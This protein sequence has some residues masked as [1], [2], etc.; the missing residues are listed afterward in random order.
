MV[1]LFGHAADGYLRLC[2]DLLYR[3]V[4]DDDVRVYFRASADG[5]DELLQQWLGGR[6]VNLLLHY[7]AV[8]VPFERR[9]TVDGVVGLGVLDVDECRNG[10]VDNAFRLGGD[11]ERAVALLVDDEERLV[12]VYVDGQRAC[13]VGKH[14]VAADEV[15]EVVF[16]VYHVRPTAQVLDELVVGAV[17]PRI[18]QPF[19]SP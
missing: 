6:W 18:G 11:G 7:L 1:V 15:D 16:H 9:R 12:F 2:V 13:F 3:F 10:C 17:E 19:Q 4:V 14:M 5:L 8:D